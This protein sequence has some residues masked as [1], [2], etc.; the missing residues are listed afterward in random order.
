MLNTTLQYA[1]D[2]QHN[3]EH[4]TQ[5]QVHNYILNMNIHLYSNIQTLSDL[6]KFRHTQFRKSKKF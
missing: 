4:H 2:T 5:N 6:H 3:N 1:V